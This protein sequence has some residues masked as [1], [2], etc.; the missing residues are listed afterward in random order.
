[1]ILAMDVIL[2][3]ASIGLAAGLHAA[4]RPYIPELKKPPGYRE[5]ALILWLSV[6]LWLFLSA[7]GRGWACCSTC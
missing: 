4:L 2:V 6:P 7:S 1:V 5:Y 3:V